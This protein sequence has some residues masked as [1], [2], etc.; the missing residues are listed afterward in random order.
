MLTP[1]DLEREKYEARLKYQRDAQAMLQDAVQRGEK[2]DEE[3]GELMGRVQQAERILKRESTASET[4]R[5]MP[6]DQL[7]QLAD[8]LEA[9]LAQRFL[10]RSQPS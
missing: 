4:L 2:F 1:S 3:R 9:Q 10:L 8:R 6:Q 7:L 5:A